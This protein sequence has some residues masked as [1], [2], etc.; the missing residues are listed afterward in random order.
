MARPKIDRI[1]QTTLMKRCAVVSQLAA[2]NATNDCS[3]YLAL[4]AA[5]VY[6]GLAAI[7][8]LGLHDDVQAAEAD[9][10]DEGSDE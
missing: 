10:A 3:K 5:D 6:L 2:A 9:L 8:E 1:R 4:G 7:F